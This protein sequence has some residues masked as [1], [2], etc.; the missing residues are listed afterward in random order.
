MKRLIVLIIIFCFALSIDGNAQGSLFF[1][2][3]DFSLVKKEK[4]ATYIS[5]NHFEQQGEETLV[6]LALDG[7][8]KITVTFSDGNFIRQ[9]PIPASIN[10]IDDQK[11]TEYP[12][13]DYIQFN[14]FDEAPVP[15]G[16]IAALFQFIAE[17]VVYPER[18]K[19]KG[20]QGRVF[21]Q[22]LVNDHG[23]VTN[24]SLAKG[25]DPEIDAEAARLIKEFS[26][27]NGWT[28][29][30]LAGEPVTIHVIMPILFVL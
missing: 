28:P 26:K 9:E 22:F 17:N 23:E 15:N 20:I 5:K 12:A 30:L 3:Q 13:E 4:K 29:G 8:G 14:D 21:V 18:A 10:N 24:I 25:I 1:F 16:G 6:L 2:D 7:S 27:N 11:L 19:A